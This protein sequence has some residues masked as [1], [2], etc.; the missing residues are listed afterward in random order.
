M[1]FQKYARVSKFNLHLCLQPV[2][3]FNVEGN[4]KKTSDTWTGPPPA[5]P[6]AASAAEGTLAA[7]RRIS[8]GSTSSV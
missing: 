1:W 6:P 2:S 3:N 8:A 7:S 5:S 4:T